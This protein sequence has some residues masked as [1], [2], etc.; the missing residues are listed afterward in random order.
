MAGGS[1][2]ATALQD[3]A[4]QPPGRARVHVWQSA[5]D[6]TAQPRGGTRVGVDGGAGS[7]GKLVLWSGW[8][9]CLAATWRHTESW[10]AGEV[11][12]AVQTCHEHGRSQ[13]IPA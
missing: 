1:R 12:A 9:V 2:K 8:S 4:R 5:G 3:K 11:T 7:A 10:L 13:R 6:A